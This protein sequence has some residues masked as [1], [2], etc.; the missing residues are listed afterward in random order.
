MDTVASPGWL[1]TVPLA[2][3]GLHD[4]EV[5]ENTLAAFEAARHAGVGIEL[6]VR[7]SADGTPVVFHDRHLDRLTDATG[8]VEALT[9]ERLAAV[10]VGGSDQGIPTLAAALAAAGDVPVMV[11]VKSEHAR[12]GLLEPAVAEVLADHA[13]PTCVASFNPAVLRWFLRLRPDVPRVLTVAAGSRGRTPAG[14][15][16]IRLV[17]PHALSV[18]LAALAVPGVVERRTAGVCIVTWTVR[19]AGHLA[20]ARAA[21]DNLIFERLPVATILGGEPGTGD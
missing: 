9:V 11:E 4:D 19:S 3:R 10:R 5:P 8:P 13:G 14:L 17:R 1:A 20:R 21:A 2:H 15:R 18:D 12:A 16:A 7:L 6:D